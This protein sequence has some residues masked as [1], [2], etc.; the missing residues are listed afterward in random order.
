MTA[1]ADFFTNGG[2]L[3]PASPVGFSGRRNATVLLG[4]NTKDRAKVKVW[5]IMMMRLT[6][7]RNRLTK[8]YKILQSDI[9]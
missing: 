5:M 7:G 9:E 3:I 6:F 8:C 4:I 2:T 1:A